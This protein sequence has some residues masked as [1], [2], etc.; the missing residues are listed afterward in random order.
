MLFAVVALFLALALHQCDISL[1]GSVGMHGIV[2]QCS[3]SALRN[4]RNASTTIVLGIASLG[5]ALIGT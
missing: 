4:V 5:I 2:V 3:T 1:A